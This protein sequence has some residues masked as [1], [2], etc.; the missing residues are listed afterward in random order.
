MPVTPSFFSPFPV[1]DVSSGLEG[2]PLCYTVIPL[3]FACPAPPLSSRSLFPPQ[4][5]VFFLP[6]SHNLASTLHARMFSPSFFSFVR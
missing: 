1:V 2:Y 5:L 3:S 4:L 6:L